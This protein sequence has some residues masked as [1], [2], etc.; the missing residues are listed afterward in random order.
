MTR[1]ISCIFTCI[2]FLRLTLMLEKSSMICR[3]I[4]FLTEFICSS[5]LQDHI[6]IITYLVIY[7]YRGQSSFFLVQFSFSLWAL[8]S[9]NLNNFSTCCACNNTYSWFNYL[10][11]TLSFYVIGR[12]L[13]RLRTTIATPFSSYQSALQARQGWTWFAN[14]FSDLL[15]K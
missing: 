8:L 1:D 10:L 9:L 5:S 12:A 6:T 14:I 3:Y 4:C 13:C 15:N 2:P 7:H 11:C